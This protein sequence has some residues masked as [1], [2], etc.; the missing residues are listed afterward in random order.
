M[1]KKLIQEDRE[2]SLLNPSVSESDFDAVK[3]KVSNLFGLIPCLL[4]QRVT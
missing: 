2:K 1:D 3:S 4:L